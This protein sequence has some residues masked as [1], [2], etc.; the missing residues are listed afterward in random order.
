M[1]V[2]IIEP[3]GGHGGMDYYDYGLAMG[4]GK[5][6][7]QI[8]YH[9]CSKT[10]IKKYENVDTQ[11]TFGRIWERWKLFKGLQFFLGYIT[12]FIIS[13]KNG[14]D[15][16]HLHFFHVE[17]RNYIVLFIARKILRLK[18]V[19]TIHDVESFK[20][21][22]GTLNSA[23]HM[24]DQIIVHNQF[25]EQELLQKGV[26]KKKIHIVPHGNYLPFINEGLTQP[27]AQGD[28]LNLLFFGQIKEVKGLDVLLNALAVVVEEKDHVHLTIAGRPWHDDASKYEDFIRDL[29]LENFVTTRFEFI[30]DDEVADYFSKADVVV[31]PY[32]KIYQSGVLLLA[33]SYRKPVLVSDLEPFTEI[34]EH[35]KTGFIFESESEEDL[36][37]KIKVIIEKREILQ[38]VKRNA[39]VLLDGEYDWVRIGEKTKQIYQS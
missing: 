3:V 21:S 30:P 29:S 26:D 23:F 7:C 35:K 39:Q 12:S 18:V 24:M 32:K 33:M 20:N 17:L 31:L 36:A 16:V 27:K 38:L 37:E 6:G 14:C 28:K 4:L 22:N 13:K 15:V 11:H 34:I 1:K 10:D 9:T 2:A 5:N 25:S 19:V 8:T